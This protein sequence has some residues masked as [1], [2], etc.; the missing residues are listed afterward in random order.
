MTEMKRRKF[1]HELLGLI[2][3]SALVA[4][5]LFLVVTN[6]AVTIAEVYCLEN[7]VPMTEF[8]WMTVDRWIFGSGAVIAIGCF[9]VLFLCLLRERM[10]YI[11]TIAA[12]IDALGAGQEALELPMQGNN[13]LTALALAVNDMAAARQQIRE[14]EQTLAKEKDQLIRTLSHDIRTPLTSILAYSEY[15]AEA[16]LPAE[17]RKKH[18]LMVRRK[19][20][21]IRELTDILLDGGKRNLERFEN[22]RLLM[23]QLAQEWAGELEDR[24]SVSLDLD[25]CSAFSGNFDVQELRRILDN[26]GSNVTKYADPASPVC[27]AVS[28]AEKSLVIRQTNAVLSA[29]APSDSYGIGLNS[30]RRIAQHYSGRVTT[31]Q[32]GQQFAITIELAEY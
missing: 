7:D 8:D 21:Q 12:G 2:G 20:Q 31:Q 14:K 32:T 23:E 19:A 30:I 4:L 15:L 28:T 5:I 24:F 16:D 27:L 13:E 26:L 10:A 1:A 3:I 9:S 29:A 22:A 25:G 6:I 17:E 11:R 18:L